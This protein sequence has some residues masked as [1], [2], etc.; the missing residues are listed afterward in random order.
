MMRALALLVAALLLAACT[1]PRSE[2]QRVRD[3]LQEVETLAEGRDYMSL[4]DLIAGDYMDS[5]GND[6]LKAAAILRAFYLRNREVHLYVR[7]GEISFPSPGFAKV[8]VHVA[9]ARRPMLESEAARLPVANMH[10]VQ[11]E[12][13]ESGDSYEILRSEWQRGN[14][15]N[16]VF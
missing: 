7:P 9:M 6:K 15:T 4:V 16:L 3:F 11:L 12:L 2:E 1:D 14:A 8:T 13:L 5:R 10:E